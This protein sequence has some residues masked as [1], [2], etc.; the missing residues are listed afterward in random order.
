[1]YFIYSPCFDE[2]ILEIWDFTKSCEQ[3]T[4]TGGTSKLSVVMQIKRLEEFVKA[5]KT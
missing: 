1:M 2:D 3:Y 5:W 4:V